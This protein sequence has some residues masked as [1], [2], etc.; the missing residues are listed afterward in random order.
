[1]SFDLKKMQKL[2]LKIREIEIIKGKKIFFSP[3]LKK[4]RKFGRQKVFIQKKKL[5]KIVK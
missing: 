1:M 5:K 2:V 3:I 4:S